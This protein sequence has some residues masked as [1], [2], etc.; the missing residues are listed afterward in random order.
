M[1]DCIK[2]PVELS[3]ETIN[4][5]QDCALQISNIAARKKIRLLNDSID[6]EESGLLVYFKNSLLDQC[7]KFIKGFD[8][9][10]CLGSFSRVNAEILAQAFLFDNLAG[11]SLNSESITDCDCPDCIQKN[12]NFNIENERFNRLFPNFLVDNLKLVLNNCEAFDV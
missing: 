10:I 9:Y 1:S 11:I 3:V 6:Y 2:Y 5:I 7:D 12:K 8:Y 4:Q